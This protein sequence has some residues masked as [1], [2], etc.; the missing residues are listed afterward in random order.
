MDKKMV[1]FS[2]I[3]SCIMLGAM[4]VGQLADKDTHVFGYNYN[5]NVMETEFEENGIVGLVVGAL[6]GILVATALLPV[7]ADNINTLEEDT[8][9]NFSQDEE[10]LIGTW[11]LL[12]IVGIMIAIVGLA[13]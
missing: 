3:A 6:V 9:D 1:L 7:I 5:I 10:D 12:I 11:N 2:V 8:N 13:L 4:T